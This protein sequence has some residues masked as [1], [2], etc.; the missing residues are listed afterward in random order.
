MIE[1]RCP[2]PSV[3]LHHFSRTELSDLV[4]EHGAAVR[5][6]GFPC[7]TQFV[8]MAFCYLWPWLTS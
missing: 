5:T 1:A 3:V 8:A 2:H 4:K 6:K 7:W